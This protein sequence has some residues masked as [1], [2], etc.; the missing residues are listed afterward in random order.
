MNNKE[1]L[2]N[3]DIHSYDRMKTY[4]YEDE[5]QEMLTKK[6]NQNQIHFIVVLDKTLYLIEQAIKEEKGSFHPKLQET[7]HLLSDV[8]DMVW[9]SV[10]DNVN[11]LAD[12]SD[13]SKPKEKI[14][15]DGHVYVLAK[16]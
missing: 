2:N 16:D 3:H 12:D 11:P 15:I 5:R 14:V 13:E 8:R 1:W 6:Y 9:Q 10:F 4:S 7:L